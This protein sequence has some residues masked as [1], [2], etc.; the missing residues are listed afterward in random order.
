MIPP[1][2]NFKNLKKNVSIAS[3]LSDKGLS[4]RFKKRGDRLVGSCPIHGGDNPNAFVVSLSKNNW[5]CFTGCNTGG[6][7]V[8]FV[9]F[10]DGKSYIQVAEYLAS[11]ANIVPR[12]DFSSP[13]S[14]KPFRPFTMRLNLDHNSAFIKKKG[15]VPATAKRFEAGAY[16]GRGFLEDCIGVRLYDLDG[17]PLGYTGRRLKSDQIKEYGKWK[18]PRNFPKQTTLYNYH[19]IR[20]NLQKGLVIVECP[21]GVMRLT[22]LNIPAVALLGTS[23][24][25]VHKD[26]LRQAPQVILMLDGDNPGQLATAGLQQSLNSMTKVHYVALTPDLDPDDYDD[27]TLSSILKHFSL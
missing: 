15:I 9:R 22:Q 18:I 25:Q 1:H 10:L 23:L 21:W 4:G 14:N 17:R 11:L 7:I 26:L 19:R 13:P 27:E 12:S 20:Q 5:Y 2:L 16:S 3:V 24:S 6:D 8:D